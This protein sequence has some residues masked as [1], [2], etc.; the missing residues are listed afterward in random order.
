MSP[1]HAVLAIA[2]LAQPTGGAVVDVLA[3]VEGGGRDYASGVRRTRTTMRIGLAGWLEEAPAHALAA[4]A[5]V[6][7]EP[8]AAIGV[9]LR[10]QLRFLDDFV[11]HLGVTSILSPGQMVGGSIGL[12]YEV[13]IGEHFSLGF[14]PTVNVYFAGDDLADEVILW[15]AMMGAGARVWF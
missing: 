2:A 12:A 6:E 8:V 9:D 15:Q 1:A 4:A 7:I 3:G 11:A 14:G 10:Y 13:S 5:V